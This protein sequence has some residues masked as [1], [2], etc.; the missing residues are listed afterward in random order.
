LFLLH[1]KIIIFEEQTK[2]PDTFVSG[3]FFLPAGLFREPPTGKIVPTIGKFAGIMGGR[4]QF[5][6]TATG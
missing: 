6:P 3:I 5:T 2:I 1:P 4:I